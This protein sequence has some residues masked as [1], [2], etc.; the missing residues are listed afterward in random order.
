MSANNVLIRNKKDFNSRKIKL[1]IFDFWQ[2]LVDTKNKPINQMLEILKFS[3]DD[4]DFINN[5]N[6]SCIFT[7]NFGIEINLRKFINNYSKDDRI[8]IKCINSWKD[9]SSAAFLCDNTLEILNYLLNSGYKLC[10]LTNIDKYGYE[11]FKFPEIFSYFDHLFLS[12][13]EGII[14]P[15]LRCWGLIR[16]RFNIEFKNTLMIGDSLEQDIKP[17]KIL[18]IKTIHLAG[19]LSL[20]L[21]KENL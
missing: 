14:K 12:Y 4:R 7:E 16:E 18:G 8:I 5:I 11:N 17:A 13:N 3:P 15:D 1:I 6:Q 2:T 20:D 19:D 9:A 21:I 10:L